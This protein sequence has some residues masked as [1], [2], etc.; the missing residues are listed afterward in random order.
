MQFAPSNR[1]ICRESKL[2]KYDIA[3]IVHEVCSLEPE[4]TRYKRQ[5][6][7]SNQNQ[8]QYKLDKNCSL[9][10]ESTKRQNDLSNQNHTTRNKIQKS[11][12]K[13]RKQTKE[14]DKEQKTKDIKEKKSLGPESNQ[15]PRDDSAPVKAHDKEVYSPLAFVLPDPLL[16]GADFSLVF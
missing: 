3:W 10:P 15:W 14:I 2:L 6:A 1:Y 7:L 12:R 16:V 8:Q 9:E 5:N 4:L 11:T 13:K